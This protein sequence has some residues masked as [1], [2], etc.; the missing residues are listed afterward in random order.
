M[1]VNA[2]SMYKMILK[3]RLLP[4]IGELKAELWSF[5]VD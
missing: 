3:N 4:Y 5:Q 1:K 2:D